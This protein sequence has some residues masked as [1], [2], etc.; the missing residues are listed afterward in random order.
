MVNHT[1]CFKI[2]KRLDVGGQDKQ[3]ASIVGTSKEHFYSGITTNEYHDSSGE[4]LE[5][6][7]FYCHGPGLGRTLFNSTKAEHAHGAKEEGRSYSGYS[8]GWKTSALCSINA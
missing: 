2:G 4:V 8:E 6:E 7:S 5:A 1:D 3:L